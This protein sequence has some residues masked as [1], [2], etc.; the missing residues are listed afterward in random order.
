MIAGGDASRYPRGNHFPASLAEVGFADQA[1]RATTAWPRAA[2]T[3]RA[4]AGRDPG[5]DWRRSPPPGALKAGESARRAERAVAMSSRRRI[6]RLLGRDLLAL[7]RAARLRVSRVS[8]AGLG[9][10]RAARRARLSAIAAAAGR[11][12]D[13]RGARRGGPDCRADRQSPRA[14]LSA[15]S[16]RD[17]DRLRRLHGRHRVAGAGL[18]AGRRRR[19]RVR[20]APREG[21]RAERRRAEGQG[22]IVVLADARQRFEPETVRALDAAVRGPHRRRRERR[23]D[24]D[25]GA[26]GPDGGPRGRRS[27]GATRSSSGRARAASTRRWARPARSTRS[28]ASCSSRFR[29]TRC[30]TTC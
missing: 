1:R 26:R 13:R 14:R 20:G 29:P 18:C 30:S 10:R 8:R 3:A 7:R 16:A 9:A 12:R 19:A 6:P 24:A 2:A 11:E 27:T 17:P 21:R 28:G 23:A 5:V 15:R 22:Q 25:R 4:A